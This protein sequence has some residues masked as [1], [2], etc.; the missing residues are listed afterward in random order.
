[1]LYIQRNVVLFRNF[2]H[3]YSK[4]NINNGLITNIILS[5]LNFFL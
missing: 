4:N 3:S 1:M 2:I 5:E